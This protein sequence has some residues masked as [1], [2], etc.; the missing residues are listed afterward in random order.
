MPQNKPGHMARVFDDMLARDRS[1]FDKLFSV[2]GA[3][4]RRSSLLQRPVAPGDQPV[5][6]TEATDML[7]RR[8]GDD[9]RFDIVEQRREGGEL[10]VIGKVSIPSRNISATQSASTPV[11]AA[12]ARSGRISGT[13]DGIAFSAGSDDAGPVQ[14]GE[15]AEE[16]ALRR[17]TDEIIRNC[18]RWL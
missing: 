16:A 13:A 12:G 1:E 10:I 9:W 4:G 3:F 18:L 8:F 7:S 17:A 6:Q 11:P 14:A 5:A 2:Q 15:S